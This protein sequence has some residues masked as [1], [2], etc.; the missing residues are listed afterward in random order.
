MSSSMDTKL[1]TRRLVTPWANWSWYDCYLVDPSGNRYSP[2]MVMTSLWAAELAHELTGS[3]LQVYSLRNE[4][5]KRLQQ[6]QA[7]SATPEITVRWQGV[8]TILRLP[9]SSTAHNTYCC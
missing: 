3:P 1:D 9:L 2:E 4:L 7:L 8:E 6:V 5:R